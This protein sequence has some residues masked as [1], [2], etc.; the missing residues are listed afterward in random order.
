MGLKGWLTSMGLN[1]FGLISLGLFFA[2]FLAILMW[3]FTRSR[4]EIE[5][6]SRLWEDDDDHG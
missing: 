3:T 4:Q 5:V 2:S 6:Q 1:P